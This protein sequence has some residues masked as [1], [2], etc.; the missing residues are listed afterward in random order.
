MSTQVPEPL[1]RAIEQHQQQVLTLLQQQLQR[2]EPNAA[3]LLQASTPLWQL[4]QWFPRD[5]LKREQLERLRK[6][7]PALLQ[8]QVAA[9]Q[10]KLLA[11]VHGLQ[12]QWSARINLAV[13]RRSSAEALQWV[14]AIIR[15]QQ[16]QGLD[17]FA[18][19]QAQVLRLLSAL[20]KSV[21]EKQSLA[22]LCA[23]LQRMQSLLEFSASTVQQQALATA[24]QVLSLAHVCSA[25][26]EQQALQNAWQQLW[27]LSQGEP[28][29]TAPS[30]SVDIEL[31]EAVQNDLRGYRWQLQHFLQPLT[32]QEE[33]A[34]R[35][36][37][38]SVLL[39]YYRLPWV[40]AAAGQHSAAQ[41][42]QVAYHLLL[43]HWQQRLPIHTALHQLLQQIARVLEMGEWSK[44]NATLLWRWQQQLLQFYCAAE[45]VKLAA[46]PTMLSRSFQALNAL[47]SCTTAC[48]EKFAAVQGNITTELRLLEFGAAAVRM[49]AIEQFCSALL[50]LL[51]KLRAAESAQSWPSM[52]LER[53]VQHLLALLD[54]AAAWQEPQLDSELLAELQR[55]DF[56]VTNVGASS[57]DQRMQL[58]AATLARTLEQPLRLELSVAAAQT[59]ADSERCE[60]VVQT[61][62]R[63]LLLHCAQQSAE[64][65][66]ACLP[67]TLVVQIAIAA[68]GCVIT[69]VEPYCQLPIEEAVLQRWQYKLSKL[70]IALS[71]E[72]NKAGRRWRLLSAT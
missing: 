9:A 62:L 59:E 6:L 17:Q 45:P 34:G 68:E 24:A 30:D 52:L 27:L 16:R 49:S 32:A 58:F 31:L 69:A 71:L 51:L 56:N 40:L 18:W 33:N 48:A 63:L 28:L 46:V 36:L 61:F 2:G 43:T 38:F 13:L 10:I 14:L 8:P 12:Q 25:Q 72:M 4:A 41:L 44:C 29:A 1:L 54:E 19:Q 20:A 42:T 55:V 5:H 53:S 23:G 35:A 50:A 39:L 70:Q 37:P 65:R 3:V 60:N 67:R 64:R 21:R 57:L 47:D 26:V 66:L 11:Y 22:A 7:L 15:A